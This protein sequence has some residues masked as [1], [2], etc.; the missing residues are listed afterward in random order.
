[1]KIK[2]ELYD[3]VNYLCRC[4]MDRIGRFRLDYDF[5]PNEEILKTA[6]TELFKAA[7]IFHS[8]FHDNHIVPKWIVCDYDI[9][10]AVKFEKTTNI[11]ENSYDFLTKGIELS[12]NI[13]MKIAVFHNDDKCAICFRW[14]HM[15]IDGGGFKQFAY[16]LIKAYNEIEK[17]GSCS[18][19]F[20]RG[21]RAYTD[22]YSDFDK[23]TAKKAKLQFLGNTLKE[24]K[25]LPFTP[26]SEDDKVILVVKNFS[27][28]AFSN[29]KNVAKQVG[30]TVNDSL[31]A[32]Y[33]RAVYKVADIYPSESVGI[34]CAVDLRRYIKDINKIGYTNHTTFMPCVVKCMGENYIDTVRAVSECTKKAKEDNFL[35]LHGIPLLNIGYSTMIHAQAELVIKQFYSNANLALSN[36]GNIGKN[37]FNISGHEPTYGFGAGG[38]KIKPCAAVTAVTINNNLTIT[39]AIQGNKYDKTMVEKFFD[40]MEKE[41]E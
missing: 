38:A 15:I 35:G 3:K 24:K 25:T 17:T 20:R 33:I 27:S 13:Q 16:D 2:A 8:K 6:L 22:V 21:S 4:Y 10:E 36:V 19:D 26:K 1:M 7:P 5:V 18:R 37:V 9:D 40:V 11:E 28:D 29:A 30:A 14:N 12:D 31:V 39:M 34:S 41:M 32:A 23:K